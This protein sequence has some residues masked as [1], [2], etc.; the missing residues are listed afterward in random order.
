MQRVPYLDG[1]RAVAVLSVVAYHAR[2][3]V[4]H[5]SASSPSAAALEFALGFGA[6]G[7]DL[8]FVVSGFCLAYPVLH[9]RHALGSAQLDVA[10]YAT[11]RILRIVPPYYTAIFVLL[12]AGLLS[13]HFGGPHFLHSAS[14]AD[15][16]RQLCFFDAGTNKINS[17]FWTLPIE[18]RWYV[19]F[20][21]LLWLWMRKPRAFVAL[22]CGVVL[23]YECT[24]FG[25]LDA[26]TLPGFMLGIIAAD[27]AASGH[28]PRRWAP[29]LLI[30]GVIAGMLLEPLPTSRLVQLTDVS[31]MTSN[32]SLAWQ[33]A[34]FGFVVCAGQC[35]LLRRCL[36]LPWLT[37]IGTASYA[38]YLVHQPIVDGLAAVLPMSHS[39]VRNELTVGALAVLGGIAF[40]FIGERPFLA[41]TWRTRVIA[42]LEP[43][44]AAALRQLGL[45]PL[46]ERGPAAPAHDAAVETAAA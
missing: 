34:A 33:L 46:E 11:R 39:F 8:F 29:L 31:R 3:A 18:M 37:F 22:G 19:L 43:V 7:V 42:T 12:W 25:G 26:V 35:A 15:I 6:H 9:R 30:G 14:P 38:I 2:W 36:S 27:W 20:P 4:G 23:A 24:L 16:L 1:V 17:S 44:L 32:V 28:A 21:P 40:H 41:A 5:L 45:Q 10:R 13:R